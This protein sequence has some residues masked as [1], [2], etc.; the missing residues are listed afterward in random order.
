MKFNTTIIIATALLAFASCQNDNKNKS[1]ANSEYLDTPSTTEEYTLTKVDQYEDYLLALDTTD[2]NSMTKA[3][4]KFTE[5]FSKDDSVQN[6]EAI[7]K[8]LAYQ[9]K[10][11][12]NGNE[13]IIDERE[14]YSSLV[15]VEYNNKKIP[16]E[17][18]AFHK[19]INQNGFRIEQSEGM[20]YI[21]SSP[22]YIEQN[23]YRYASPTMEI[24]LRQLAKENIEGFAAD[25]AIIIPFETFVQRTVWWEDFSQSVTNPAIRSK[26][27]EKYKSYL[28][29]LTVGMNNTPAINYEN[30]AEEYFVNAYTYLE[31]V[32]PTSDT[33]TTLRP[34]INL[35][36][37]NKIAEA[38]KMALQMIKSE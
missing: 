31:E 30:K 3:T 1:S 20:Y 17:L 10:V 29:F 4:N 37:G 8:F 36:K 7:L 23:F 5:I 16:N 9:E 21:K 38:R 22:A 19:Q 24:Y 28:L 33:F 34:Y 11:E 26:A 15:D 27:L 12:L 32:H 2:I 14:D 35:I 13:K 18:S 25:G 6:D